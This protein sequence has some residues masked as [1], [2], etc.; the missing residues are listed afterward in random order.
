MSNHLFIGYNFATT[1]LLAAFVV[2][3]VVVLVSL[4]AFIHRCRARPRASYKRL[5]TEEF[6]RAFLEFGS[7]YQLGPRMADRETVRRL[8]RFLK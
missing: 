5:R 8:G 6:D 3:V 7:T 1:P 4:G 2:L